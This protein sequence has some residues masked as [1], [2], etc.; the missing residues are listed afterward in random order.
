MNIKNLIL[1]IG[2]VIVFGLAL[3]QGIEAFKPSPQWDDFCKAAPAYPIEVGKGPDMNS[4]SC[5]EQGGKWTNN[6]CDFYSECQKQFDDAQKTQSKFIFLVSLIV[7]ILALIIG[8]SIL[9]IEP[10]GS[11]LLGSGIWSIF[12]GS[13]VNWRNFSD[14]WRFLLLL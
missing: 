13:V 3:W 12:W 6:Y 8:Y 2:I 7:G 4:A 5:I 14:I 9:S 10:V 1:G 11:A